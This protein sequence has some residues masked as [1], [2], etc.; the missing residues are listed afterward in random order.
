M[1]FADTSNTAGE[2]AIRGEN[3][4]G[5]DGVVGAGR[6][7][8]VGL[9]DDYQGVYGKSRDNAGVVGES[10]KMH[11][12]FG[13]THSQF[14]GV[15]GA[16]DAGGTGVAGQST[17]GRGVHGAS[18][19]GP[20][21]YGQS[22]T[23]RGVE[24]WSETSYGVTGDSRTFPGVRGTSVEGRGVEGWSTSGAGVIGIS[25]QDVG[26]VGQGGRLAGLFNGG[27]DVD[28]KLR[29]GGVD[30]VE[31][32]GQL[33]D[34][35]AAL[36]AA[37][38]PRWN[39]HAQQLEN[40]HGGVANVR[41]TGDGF[42]RYATAIFNATDNTPDNGGFHGIVRS[43]DLNGN[44]DFVVQARCWPGTKLNIDAVDQANGAA[45]STTLNCT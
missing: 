7:G 13:I 11:A 15:F 28:G 1:A 38:A 21:V 17:S 25:A 35:V 32:I 44:F 12:V 9:S 26:V 16:S 40:A 23:A 10:E 43:A 31:L 20:G 36:E 19:S 29:V 6:R 33:Q 8:I 2:A 45:A 4:A 14:A 22:K 37:I 18:D 24:G 30:L 42:V 3:T 39:I 34:R 41:I 5:G 27:V